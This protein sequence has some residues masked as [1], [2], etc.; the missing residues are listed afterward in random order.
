MTSFCRLHPPPQAIPELK[1][2]YMCF[3]QSTLL[4]ALSRLVLCFLSDFRFILNS[5]NRQMSFAVCNF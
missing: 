5:V 1:L 2:F 3:V 4:H